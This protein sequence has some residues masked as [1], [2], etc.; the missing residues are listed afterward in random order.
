[1]REPSPGREPAV[2]AWVRFPEAP[3]QVEAKVVGWTTRAVWVEFT[4]L[5]GATYRAWVWK[6]AVS[7]R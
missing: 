6:S 4:M 1:V 2:A 5:S 7:P 3:I